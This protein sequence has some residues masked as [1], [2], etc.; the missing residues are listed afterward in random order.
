MTPELTALSQEPTTPRPPS[1]GLAPEPE[2]PGQARDGM[3]P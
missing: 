2:D 1:R 3:S